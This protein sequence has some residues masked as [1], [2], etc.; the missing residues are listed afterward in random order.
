MPA[1]NTKAMLIEINVTFQCDFL[2]AGIVSSII[3]ID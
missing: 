1:K 3:G 2:G